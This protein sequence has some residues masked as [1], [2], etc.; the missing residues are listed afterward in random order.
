MR[1]PIPA[2]TFHGNMPRDDGSRQENRMTNKP[3]IIEK[4]IEIVKAI[5]PNQ[6]TGT[7]DPGDIACA[8]KQKRAILTMLENQREQAVV[9][10][11]LISKKP[12]PRRPF[13]R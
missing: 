9:R 13:R 1:M 10:Q 5:R 8:E 11:D 6:V 12:P 2:R 4:F 7:T 3:K